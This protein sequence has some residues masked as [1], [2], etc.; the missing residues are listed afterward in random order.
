MQRV[1][2]VKL[3]CL[4]KAAKHWLNSGMFHTPRLH[5]KDCRCKANCSEPGSELQL[6]TCTVHNL[7]GNQESRNPATTIH[8]EQPFKLQTR[9]DQ[10]V[11]GK[12]GDALLHVP[13]GIR[14]P[15][16]SLL[17][18]TGTESKGSLC[19]STSDSAG[20]SVGKQQR[21]LKYILMSREVAILQSFW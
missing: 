5:D 10:H 8:Q 11:H 14:S 1:A 17:R 9:N 12:Q 3:A 6:E 2:R 15:G 7:I 4:N 21:H 13:I 19:S 16:A 18:R 20:E